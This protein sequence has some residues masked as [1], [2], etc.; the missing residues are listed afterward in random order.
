M[1]GVFYV[2]MLSLLSSA[3]LRICAR[4]DSIVIWVDIV[5][6]VAEPDVLEQLAVIRERV[7][8]CVL[9]LTA[10]DLHQKELISLK[11][12]MA[13]EVSASGVWDIC[14]EGECPRR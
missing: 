12:A 1:W 3:Y 8:R 7:L 2:S 11:D 13:R 14:V 6:D 5:A 10:D 9:V 4:S